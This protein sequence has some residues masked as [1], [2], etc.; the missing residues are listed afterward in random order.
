[1]D[2]KTK[3]V[4]LVDDDIDYLTQM[5]MRL[6]SAQY[7]VL[8]ADTE[9]EAEEILAG[10]RPDVAVLDLMMENMDAGFVLCHRIKKMD[11]K[12]PVI[13]VT[14][15]SSETGLDFEAAT[16]GEKAWMKADV[17]LTKPVRFEQLQR[18][19]DRLLKA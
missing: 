1:M 4:L 14:A 19:I 3:T 6:E 15:V 5:R 10:T 13:L 11:A 9:K 18:E 12:I 7:R 17:L 2:P 16:P 8:T